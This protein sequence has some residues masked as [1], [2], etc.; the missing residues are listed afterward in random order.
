ME[1]RDNVVYPYIPNSVSKIK[2]EMLKEIGVEKVEELYQSIP[3]HLRVKGK[4]NIPGPILSEIELKHHVEGIINQNKSCDEYVN[5]LGAGCY[6]HYVPA[7]CDEINGRSEFLT[8]YCGDTY[9]DHG[10]CQAIFEYTSLIGELLE[11]DVVGLATYDGG[12]AANTSI[13]MAHRINGRKEVLIPEIIDKDIV[14][15][16]KEYCDFMEI[17]KI[18]ANKATGQLDLDDLKDK[19]S[20]KT[21][22]V[23]IENPNFLGCIEEQ[24]EKISEIAHSYGAEFVV[25]VDP[26][27]LGVLET[28]AVYGG[29]IICGELQ[30]LGIHM[31]YGS[32][33]GGIIASKDEEKYIMNFPNH[34]YSLYE[35]EKGEFGFSRS[36]NQ[37]TSYHSREEAVEFLGTNVGLWAITAAVYLSLLGPQGMYEVGRNILYKSNYAKK[38]LGEIKGVEILYQ[39]SK[40]FK[41][42]VV[43]FDRTGKTVEEINRQLLKEK[44]FG[45]YDLSKDFTDLG[46]S[47]LYCVTETTRKEDIENLAKAVE[48]ILLSK[49]SKGG[50]NE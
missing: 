43:N 26:I 1:K 33:L 40:S 44:I 25:S 32:G 11:M 30:A 35:N 9:S 7:V 12:Q 31:G 4:L 8:A 24:G 10:K 15:Q 41:E 20:E 6:N 22:C 48:R 18:K 50:K 46:Q 45:G 29:D 38:V 27:S 34:F 2:E 13:R 23:Y 37:R 21:A 5:F 36:L 49:D 16:I 42:F 28:P 17:K 39:E 47:A 19:I 3:K 14:N